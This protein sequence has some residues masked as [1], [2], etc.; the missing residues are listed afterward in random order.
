L[1]IGAVVVVSITALAG[2]RRGLVVG[3]CSL[4]GLAVGAYGGAEIAPHVVRGDASIYPPLVALV[5]GVIGAGI[6]QWLAVT[7][8]RSVRTLLRVGL[9][10][11]VDNVG[12][13]LLGAAT[14]IVFVWLV[15]VL[16]L[17]APG[18]KTLRRDVQR[19]HIAG[20]LVSAVP[21]A[22]VIDVLA[23]IDPFETL[24][25]PRL[26]VHPGDPAILRDPQVMAAGRSV[27]RIIGNACGLGIEGSGWIV[28]HGYVVTNAHVV[29]GVRHPYV[30]RYRGP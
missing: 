29:A 10:R 27:V 15:G 5:G 23:R 13:A 4:G 20:S 26:D 8:G 6:G 14:G 24:A 18:D 19:S 11:A 9:L 25:G 28:A 7:A 1:D 12:G 30:D 16:L 21:P 22:R 17:Y 3:V 2:F